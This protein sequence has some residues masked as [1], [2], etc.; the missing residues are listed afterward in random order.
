MRH[1]RLKFVMSL[2]LV[3]GNTYLTKADKAMAR[4]HG[5]HVQEAVDT[6]K[7][8]LGA[9]VNGRINKAG[10]EFKTTQLVHY[11]RHTVEVDWDVLLR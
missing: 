7:V 1:A 10:E 5:L 8:W 2:E 3:A 4:G 9:Y 11:D 6:L